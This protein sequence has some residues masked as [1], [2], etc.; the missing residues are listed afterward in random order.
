TS[1]RYK[2]VGDCSVTG[3]AAHLTQDF[4]GRPLDIVVHSL[5]NGPDVKKPLLETSRIGY[6]TAVGV[7]AFSMVSMMQRLGPLLCPG[8]A[9]LRCAPRSSGITGA[10]V[11]VDK[12][13]HP[14]GMPVSERPLQ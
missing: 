1:K 7:S 6:L 4:G 12:G 9:A 13:Y 14:M 2:D 10:T 5:A 11:Y 3:L 8:G